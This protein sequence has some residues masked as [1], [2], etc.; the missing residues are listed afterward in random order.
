MALVSGVES[1]DTFAVGHLATMHRRQY[2]TN[3]RLYFMARVSG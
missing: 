3:S 1:S 2:S